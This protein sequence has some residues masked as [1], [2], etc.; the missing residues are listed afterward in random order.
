MG[1]KDS[2]EFGRTMDEEKW[3]LLVVE[4]CV[5]PGQGLQGPLARAL[6]GLSLPFHHLF[7]CVEKAEQVISPSLG[8]KLPSH[9]EGTS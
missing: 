7:G 8:P 1:E 2:K 9:R 5:L 6:C 4:D 3:H